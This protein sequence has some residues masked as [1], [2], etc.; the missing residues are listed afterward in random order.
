MY[1]L[2]TSLFLLICFK[3]INMYVYVLTPYFHYINPLSQEDGWTTRHEAVGTN[4]H[5]A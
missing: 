4:V 3:W 1:A 2:I 5:H